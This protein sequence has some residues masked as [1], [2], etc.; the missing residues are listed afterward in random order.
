M[1]LRGHGGQI[2]AGAVFAHADRR[3]E[4][5]R[6]DARQQPLALF[7]VAVSQQPG[8][9]LPIGDP[10]RRDRRADG[11]QFLGHHVA[12]QM[13]QPVAAVLLRDDQPD[14]AGVAESGAEPFVPLAQPRVDGGFPAELGPVGPQE[15]AHRGPQLGQLGLVGAQRVKWNSPDRDSYTAGSG[16]DGR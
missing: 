10:V 7:F 13:A 4:P 1:A 16:V 2:R 5:A 14:E 8:S 11:E 12:V 3:V 9:D 15:I 6:R